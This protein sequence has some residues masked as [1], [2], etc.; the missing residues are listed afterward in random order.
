MSTDY[1]D[2]LPS[3]SWWRLLPVTAMTC[4]ADAEALYWELYAGMRVRH[5]RRRGAV[6]LARCPKCG[7][8]YEV[9][10]PQRKE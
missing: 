1:R 10:A 3:L 6:Y 8:D 9:L 4:P 2:N 7:K 5:Q